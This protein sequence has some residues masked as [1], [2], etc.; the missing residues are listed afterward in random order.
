MWLSFILGCTQVY[1]PQN[2]STLFCF[3]EGVLD[4]SSQEPHVI[5]GTLKE[6]REGNGSCA[7]ELVVDDGVQEHVVG[8]SVLDPFDNIQPIDISWE[9]DTMVELTLVSKQVFG[10]VEGLVLRDEQGLIMALDGGYWGTA[11]AEVELPF[12]VDWSENHEAEFISECIISKGYTQVLDDVYI[13]PFS[14][15]EYTL[16]ADTFDFYSIAATKYE[17]GETCSVSD[18]SDV[19]SWGIFRR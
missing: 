9:V 7:V 8:F 17:S 3:P 13:L 6:I 5:D 18:M 10:N 16:G 4:N 15:V 19:F 12:S 1:E 11:L 14:R 2:G